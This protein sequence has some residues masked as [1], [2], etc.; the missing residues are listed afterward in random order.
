MTN[1]RRGNYEQIVK[2]QRKSKKFLKNAWLFKISAYNDNCW[3]AKKG[4]NHSDR[5]LKPVNEETK[6]TS[7]NEEEVKEK[8]QS[9]ESDKKKKK[10]SK[11]DS[12]LEKVKEE[13][14]FK[15]AN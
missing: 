9:A 8:E 4:I 7:L 6:D 13:L 2:G 10:P 12:E 1:K 14:K 11:K 5:R 15:N 3:Q